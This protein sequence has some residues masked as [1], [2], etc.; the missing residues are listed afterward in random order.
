MR[1]RH[2]VTEMLLYRGDSTSITKFDLAKTDKWALFGAGI[3]LTSDPDIAHDY[4]MFGN[5]EHIV[6]PRHRDD[7]KAH[8]T[9]D[10]FRY[11]VK[12][13]ATQFDESR[14]HHVLENQHR[15]IALWRAGVSV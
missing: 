4:T 1:Y 2:I 7:P 6:Y 8:K 10:L 9:S 3:Y 12:R 14:L 11:Y 15:A 13:L 5:D